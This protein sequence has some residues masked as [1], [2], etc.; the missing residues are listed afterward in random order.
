MS[1]AAAIETTAQQ[2]APDLS[3]RDINGK[4]IRLSDFKGRVVLLNFWATWCVPCRAEI[5]DLVKLQRRYRARGLRIV[6]VT[7]PPEQ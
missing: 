2:K 7:Y 4:T 3:F 6:G 5:P 1:F